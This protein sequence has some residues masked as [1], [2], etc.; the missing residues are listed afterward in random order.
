MVDNA[1]RAASGLPRRRRR[2]HGNDEPEPREAPPAGHSCE[3]GKRHEPLVSGHHLDQSSDAP[4]A[5]IAPCTCFFL[6]LSWAQ[7]QY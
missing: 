6:S 2:R 7:V 1:R 3:P 5:I 4:R